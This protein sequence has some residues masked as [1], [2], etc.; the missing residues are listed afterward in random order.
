MFVDFDWGITEYEMAS[1][2][3]SSRNSSL[4]LNEANA[5]TTNSCKLLLNHFQPYPAVSVDSKL[6][7]SYG[8]IAEGS[9][10]IYVE[11]WKAIRLFIWKKT[12]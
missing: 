5:L 9:L 10:W 7:S 4:T 12:K 3:S 2:V 11:N 1:H 8:P 6:A